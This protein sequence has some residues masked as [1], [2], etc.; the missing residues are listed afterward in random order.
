M[1]SDLPAKLGFKTRSLQFAFRNNAA[2]ETFHYRYDDEKLTFVL[3]R[4]VGSLSG[5]LDGVKGVYC[6][7]IDT[8]PGDSGS[9]LLT[10]GSGEVVGMRCGILTNDDDEVTHRL[11][12]GSRQIYSHMR[13]AR[14]IAGKKGGILETC[15]LPQLGVEVYVKCSKKPQGGNEWS[16]SNMDDDDQDDDFDDGDDYDDYEASI[17]DHMYEGADAKDEMMLEEWDTEDELAQ[18][19]LTEYNMSDAEWNRRREEQQGA[20][21]QN[22]F[23]PGDR[24]K[25]GPKS[26]GED[27]ARSTA[28]TILEIVRNSPV[29]ISLETAVPEEVRVSTPKVTPAVQGVNFGDDQNRQATEHEVA[30]R[31]VRKPELPPVKV[32][33]IC[34]CGTATSNQYG[35]P[36]CEGKFRPIRAQRFSTKAWERSEGLMAKAVAAVPCS[37]FEEMIYAEEYCVPTK[38]VPF[39]KDASGED[40]LY[41]V[42]KTTKPPSYGKKANQDESAAVEESLKDIGVDIKLVWPDTDEKAVEHSLRANCLKR[43]E[44]RFTATTEELSAMNL[45][46]KAEITPPDLETPAKIRSEVEKAMGSLRPGKSAGYDGYI[47]GRSTKGEFERAY[48]D[49]LVTATTN[50]LRRL[51]FLG[52]NAGFMHPIHKYRAGLKTLVNPQIKREWHRYDKFFEADAEGNIK[53]DADGKP[54]PRKNPRWRS[55]LI[56][57]TVDFLTLVV[58]VS[59]RG[60]GREEG[61]A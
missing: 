49:E 31:E 4:N 48:H 6:H 38:A 51:A 7:G 22:T 17:P 59:R 42:G 55:I 5:P 50:R 53:L 46:G 13:R 2:F 40:F 54:V 52:S 16:S 34:G 18:E 44:D 45:I 26:S 39:E 12:V 14:M 30:Q 9:P 3:Y 41:V 58:L 37:P 28:L 24:R 1:K 43:T 47:R 33:G 10:V 29:R 25:Y 32:L 60:E 21:E 36:K 57:G 35:C 23:T 20:H 19:F 15:L 56:Q 27:E 61:W 11:A 8:K